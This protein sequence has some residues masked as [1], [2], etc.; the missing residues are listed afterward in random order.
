MD[1]AATK[2]E[3][4]AKL[5]IIFAGLLIDEAVNLGKLGLDDVHDLLG[6][7]VRCVHK[8]FASCPLVGA[9]QHAVDRRARAHVDEV[10]GVELLGVRLALLRAGRAGLGR[11]VVLVHVLHH[12]AL[13]LAR[14]RGPVL[15]PV[16]LH[17][18]RARGR[19]GGRGSGRR[20][21]RL[22]RC[23]A[24][25][26]HAGRVD[27]RAIGVGAILLPPRVLHD[28]ADGPPMARVNNQNLAEQVL[29]LVGEP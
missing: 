23:I 9:L 16:R 28:L 3:D 11:G 19:G 22:P 29:D 13:R 8:C 24:A 14:A 26:E 1:M 21:G 5:T 7:Q 25:G 12:A 10:E 15:A 6:F 18:R 17:G 27:V 20:G 4:A 2:V